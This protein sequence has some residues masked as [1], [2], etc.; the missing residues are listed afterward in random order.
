MIPVLPTL[1]DIMPETKL[2]RI[3]LFRLPVAVLAISILLAS[4][5]FSNQ[6]AL[7]Q[8]PA[9][10]SVSSPGIFYRHMAYTPSGRVVHLEVSGTKDL[11]I[12]PWISEIKKEIRMGASQVD[13]RVFSSAD[14][15]YQGM[16]R[17]AKKPRGPN[18]VPID[19]EL[20]CQI[21][22]HALYF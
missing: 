8:R 4:G 17:V 12:N 9:L 18:W 10:N 16:V 20:F 1:V 6:G 11:E 14:W 21:E 22:R 3:T 7:A 15:T 5:V 13:L 2:S 19:G